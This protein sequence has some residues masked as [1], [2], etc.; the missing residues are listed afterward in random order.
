MFKSSHSATE[1]PPLF[2]R[3]VLCSQASQLLQQPQASSPNARDGAVKR[4]V[5]DLTIFASVENNC[6]KIG[7]NTPTIHK[8]CIIYSNDSD[9]WWQLNIPGD[10]CN[11]PASRAAECKAP[12]STSLWRQRPE[13]ARRRMTPLTDTSC[14]V[15][16]CPRLGPKCNGNLGNK[17]TE[18][19][20]KLE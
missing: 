3:H 9:T 17:W 15:S 1:T 5:A 11:W 16:T 13:R 8:M 14:E 2:Q 4:H 18:E 6:S 10:E 19:P 20:Y 7:G 12:N